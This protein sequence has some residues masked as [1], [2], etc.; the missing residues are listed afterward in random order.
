M[1]SAETASNGVLN[2]LDCLICSVALT[3]T[4]CTSRAV[5]HIAK[6]FI[7]FDYYSAQHLARLDWRGVA[8]CFLALSG[9][10]G[11]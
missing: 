8:L 10:R 3:M 4:A 1:W 11:A 2:M 9:E 6:I 7:F 5:C